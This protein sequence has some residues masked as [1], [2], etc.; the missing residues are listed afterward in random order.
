MLRHSICHWNL[1][2]LKLLRVTLV[3][4]SQEI[5]QMAPTPFQQ[6]GTVRDRPDSKRHTARL[7]TPH[8]EPVQ[9]GARR[10]RCACCRRCSRRKRRSQRT[11][12]RSTLPPGH[13]PE[14][15]PIGVLHRANFWMRDVR[16]RRVPAPDGRGARRPLILVTSPCNPTLQRRCRKGQS[17]F[18]VFRVFVKEF[19]MPLVARARSLRATDRK[20]VPEYG[21]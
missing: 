16:K 9:A 21:T 15:R 14:E 6:G 18:D 8:A 10:N 5:Q 17:V 11:P 19:R 12:W 1:L 20:G 2:R 7:R 4:S 13:R 3:D